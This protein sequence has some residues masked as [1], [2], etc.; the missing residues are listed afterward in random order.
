MRVGRTYEYERK[1]D[2][3]CGLIVLTVLTGLGGLYLTSTAIEKRALYSDTKALFNTVDI[4]ESSKFDPRNN[5][6]VVHVNIPQSQVQIDH[7][8]HDPTF[9]IWVTGS[10]TLER[11]V[12]YCQWEEH[13]FET[14]EKTAYGTEHVVRTYYYTKGWT[15]YPINSLFFDQPAAH[16]NP[17]RVPVSSGV[18]DTSGIHTGQKGFSIPAY[19]M[20]RL[21]TE[22]RMFLFN[23]Q[24]LQGFKTSDAAK[25][26][27]FFYTGDGWFLSKY[28]PSTAETAMKIA[29]QYL[30]GTLFDYQLG[31]F[32]SA[33]DAGDVRV[34]F[35]G[36]TVRD[37]LSVIGLQNSDGSLSAI[38]SPSG[39]DIILIHSGGELTVNDMQKSEIGDLRS[40][41][42]WYL[43]FSIIVDL[44]TVL[45]FF[46]TISACNDDHLK[47]M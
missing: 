35:G 32:F 45:F 16:Y 17:Q 21:K 20:K 30:E 31:D 3:I 33:C 15:Y 1:E 2:P 4:V 14:T 27:Q 24:N 42:V 43:I 41:F 7:N 28:E 29:A 34:S 25:N 11:H 22:K 18:I 9:S 12:E 47:T 8:L 36:L 37:G 40:S 44:L 39:K 13:F 5:G 46:S 23:P 6:R 26:E 10:V 19:Y 38:K